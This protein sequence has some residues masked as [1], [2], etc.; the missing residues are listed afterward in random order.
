M[1][2][3]FILTK[4]ERTLKDVVPLQ[5]QTVVVSEVSLVHVI[6]RVLKH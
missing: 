5:V 3:V 4:K 6:R 1:F 2:V